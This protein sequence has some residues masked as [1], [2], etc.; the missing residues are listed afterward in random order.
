MASAG[1][2]EVRC[3]LVALMPTVVSKGSRD[4]T[5]AA[6]D[7]QRDLPIMGP[8]FLKKRA[9]LACMRSHRFNLQHLQHQ[10]P[11]RNFD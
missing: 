2:S 1:M 11:H 8:C 3:R 9:H 10:G 7:E 5:E 6:H 4:F